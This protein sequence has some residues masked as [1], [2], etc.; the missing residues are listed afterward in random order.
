MP[1]LRLYPLQGVR[2]RDQEGRVL[3]VW[4][5]VQGLHLQEEEIGTAGQSAELEQREEAN[6]GDGRRPKTF[7]RQ[8]YCADLGGV[9]GVQIPWTSH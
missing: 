5:A 3:R 9:H 1:D 7:A 2:S 4:K 8:R 6:G